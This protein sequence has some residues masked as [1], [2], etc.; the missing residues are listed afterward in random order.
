MQLVD[1]FITDMEVKIINSY[2][3]SL[4]VHRNIFI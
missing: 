1:I 2:K 3:A 4:I